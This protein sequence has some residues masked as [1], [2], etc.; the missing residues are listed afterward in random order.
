MT[1]KYLASERT[2]LFEPNAY[3]SM[4]VTLEGDLEPERIGRAV[5][6]AYAANESTMSRIM[7][8]ADGG[9]YYDR[10]EA[11]G[12]RVSVHERDM[13]TVP[14]GRGRVPAT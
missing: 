2:A 12:C 7:L 9:A 4:L 14:M 1:R 11:S 8:E 6:A 5:N 13:Q 10:L 3:I